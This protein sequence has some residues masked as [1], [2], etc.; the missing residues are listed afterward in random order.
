[1]IVSLTT[2]GASAAP[3]LGDIGLHDFAPKDLAQTSSRPR[4]EQV[5]LRH[6]SRSH[7]G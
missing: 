2:K 3:R 4:L 5:P 1:M 7:N 6:A